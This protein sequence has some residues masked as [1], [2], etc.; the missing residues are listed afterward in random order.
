M[1]TGKYL[2]IGS[3]VLLKNAKK[4]VMIIGSLP[5]IKDTEK[6][7]DYSGCVY[8]VGVVDSDN[9]LAFNHEDIDI[10]YGYGYQDEEYFQLNDKLSS[11]DPD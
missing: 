8:P 5:R 1:N 6:F 10:I 7:Y 11:V 2:P 4:K 9:L 3:I